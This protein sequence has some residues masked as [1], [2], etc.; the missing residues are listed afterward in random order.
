MIEFLIQHG[1][2]VNIRD[3]KVGNTPAGWAGHAGHVQIRDFLKA[4]ESGDS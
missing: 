2:N 4:S 3:E 1:A